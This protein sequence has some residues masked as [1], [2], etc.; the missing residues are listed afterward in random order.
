VGG[1]AA[2]AGSIVGGVVAQALTIQ[3][4]FAVCA[5]ASAVAAGVIAAAVRE[6]AMPAPVAIAGFQ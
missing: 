3:G 2:I 6:G 5:V 4:L 1:L